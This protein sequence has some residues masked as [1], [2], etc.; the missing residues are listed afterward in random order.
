MLPAL[1]ELRDVDLAHDMAVLD[2][3]RK[4]LDARSLSRPSRRSHARHHP[5]SDRNHRDAPAQT[6]RPASSHQRPAFES[7]HEP[8]RP[9]SS[10]V[11]SP[12]GGSDRAGPGGLVQSLAGILKLR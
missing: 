4:D 11:T 8:N 9:P 6:R 7:A 5:E 1:R 3:W 2:F 10:P 12:F